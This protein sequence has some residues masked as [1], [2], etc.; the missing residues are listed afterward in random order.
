MFTSDN[1]YAFGEHR[2]VGKGD[3]Y[4]ASVRVPLLVR[5]PD[6]QPGT[7]D[8]LTSNVDLVP[9]IL[10]W[11][12]VGLHATS[13]MA[14][15]SRVTSAASPSGI[16]RRSFSADAGHSVVP[17][18]IAAG[19]RATWDSTGVSVPRPTSTSSTR[20]A[21]FNCSISRR[22]PG[23]SRTSRRSGAGAADPRLHDRLERLRA[24]VAAARG[25]PPDERSEEHECRAPPLI[26][27]ASAR[28]EPDPTRRTRLR[29][30]SSSGRNPPRRC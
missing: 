4:E 23:S 1:G 27:S 21:T 18:T 20:M 22:I 24:V 6:V 17:T 11:A 3:L 8:R 28:Q 15:P 10:D 25:L 29:R 2:L 19:T 26:Q 30:K 9:T 12:K 13:S 7:I 16:L 14:R 5:G